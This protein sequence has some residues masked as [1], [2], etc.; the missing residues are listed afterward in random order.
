MNV[1][2]ADTFVASLGV[3]AYRVGGSVRDELM[4][5]PAKDADYVVRGESLDAL[6]DKLVRGG[7]RIARL[8]LA[9]MSV[10]EPL[11]RASAASKSCCR[12]PRFRLAR[13]RA[14]SPSCRTRP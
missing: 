4:G 12:E 14:T 13:D 6:R 3:E 5:R 10:G 11:R 8:K 2:A 7:A 1:A 9:S